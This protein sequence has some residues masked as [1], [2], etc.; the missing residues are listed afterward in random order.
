MSLGDLFKSNKERERDLA[1]KRRKAFREAENSVD[2]VKDRIK[3]MKMERDKSWNEARRYLKDGQKSAAQR[4]LQSVRASEVL[5]GKLEMKRWVFE[6]ILTKM[7]LAKTDNDFTQAL[8]AIN[9][10]INIDPESVADVL[11]EVEEKLGEQ[12]DTDKI[13]EK[14]YGKEME[15]AETQLSDV[16]PS[17]EDMEKQLEDEVA[18]DLSG[19]RPIRETEDGEVMPSLKQQI[20]EG[21]KRLKDLLEGDK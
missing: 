20:G 1:K 6:Q 18:A 17:M 8:N 15:G 9:V 3:K 14:M 10:V 19:A 5:M 4:S 2:A 12:L 16:V 21:R 11:G 7:E 13:W